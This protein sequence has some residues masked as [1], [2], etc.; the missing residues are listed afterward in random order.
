[1]AQILKVGFPASVLGNSPEFPTGHSPHPLLNQ[2]QAK[3]GRAA[4]RAEGAPEGRGKRRD[5]PGEEIHRW[6]GARADFP[7]CLS[8]LETDDAHHRL[9]VKGSQ[10]EQVGVAPPTQGKGFKGGT[11]TP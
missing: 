10:I 9:C 6:V 1:M 8:V 2:A 4:L 11:A 5:W 3:K 7:G